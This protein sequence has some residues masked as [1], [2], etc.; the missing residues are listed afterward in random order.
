[1]Q[2]IGGTRRTSNVTAKVGATSRIPLSMY[3]IPPVE[4]VALEDFE[5]FAIDRQQGRYSGKC[6]HE[7]LLNVPWHSSAEASRGSEGAR[8]A[9]SGCRKIC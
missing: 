2:A 3:N 5:M 9:R 8:Y 4:D 6:C 1:M 7:L